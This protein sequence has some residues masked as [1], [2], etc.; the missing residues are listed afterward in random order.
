[1][2]TKIYGHRGSAGKYPENTLLGFKHAIECG[3]DGIELDIHLTKDDQIVVVHDSTLERTTTGVGR[4]RDYTLEELSRLSAGANFSTFERFEESWKL[5][6]IPTLEEVFQLLAGTTIELNIELKTYEI[7][8]PNVEEKLLA[9]VKKYQGDRKI[10]Y[11][12]FHLPTALRLQKLDPSADVAWLL[13]KVYTYHAKDT[14]E[15]MAFESLHVDKEMIFENPKLWKEIYDKL[16]IWTVNDEAEIRE[17]INLGA[18]AVVTDFPEEAIKIRD[19][20]NEIKK[21]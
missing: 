15:E 14:L 17:L 13:W 5:E 8:Y 10:V 9:L 20:I 6:K 21:Q 19:E 1:M 11:S 16:R 18:S 7:L 12:A 2:R 3:V 4:V